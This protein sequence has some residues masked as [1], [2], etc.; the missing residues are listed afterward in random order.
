M[1]F[2]NFQGRCFIPDLGTPYQDYGKI[3]TIPSTEVIMLQKS[4]FF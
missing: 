1:I 4:Q 3:C 2:K